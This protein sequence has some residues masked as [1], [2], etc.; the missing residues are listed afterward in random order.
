M[1]R[2]TNILLTVAI[3][4]LIGLFAVT[5]T[6]LEATP[7]P[8]HILYGTASVAGTGTS[9]LTVGAKIGGTSFVKGD[10]TTGT[11]GAYGQ[12]PRSE[13]GVLGDDP[14]TKTSKRKHQPCISSTGVGVGSRSPQ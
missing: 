5:T 4:A 8:H 14:D 7:Q 6:T 11:G 2:T 3:V 1:L 12:S 9:G 13:F 10:T